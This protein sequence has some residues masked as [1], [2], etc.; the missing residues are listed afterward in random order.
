MQKSS[1]L[2]PPHGLVA[3]FVFQNRP[4]LGFLIFFKSHCGMNLMDFYVF[5]SNS[6]LIQC[7]LCVFESLLVCVSGRDLRTV[8]FID[9]VDKHTNQKNPWIFFVVVIKAKLKFCRMSKKILTQEIQ[10]SPSFTSF[11]LPKKALCIFLILVQKNVKTC[12]QKFSFLSKQY[13]TAQYLQPALFFCFLFN[14]RPWASIP[15]D[16]THLFR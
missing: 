13:H 15:K 11:H 5:I 4:V 7:P 16:L 3:L 1:P 2:P 6:F 9:T 8:R 10:Q 14:I 12:I